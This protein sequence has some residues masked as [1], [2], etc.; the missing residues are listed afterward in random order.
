MLTP[1]FLNNMLEL[2]LK[3][4]IPYFQSSSFGI[5]LSA[6][7]AAS[8][9]VTA[10]LLHRMASGV[11]RQ[12]SGAVLAA[13]LGFLLSFFL[14]AR[15]F[16][17]QI[18]PAISISTIAA[19][20]AILGILANVTASKA[21]RSAAVVLGLLV[22]IWSCPPQIYEGR[23]TIFEPALDRYAPAAHSIL[24]VSTR[25]SDG[26]PFV[27]EKGMVWASRFPTL[28]LV[29]YVSAVWQKGDLPNDPIVKA[30]LNWTVSDIDSMRPDIVFIAQG[31]AQPYVVDRKFDFLAFF[32]NDPRFAKIWREYE[33]REQ[34]INFAVYT[35][36]L[37]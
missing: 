24:I 22:A 31:E 23:H 26:F 30:A 1:E 5:F 25:V 36:K 35:R 32:N 4:Y 11:A 13:A 34:T 16:Q 14:Q 28:W 8:A 37:K 3:A 29:P 19:A 6:R 12:V 9:M 17:Y 18:L 10:F 2:G 33:L 20:I 27:L 7:P 21:Y 15:G